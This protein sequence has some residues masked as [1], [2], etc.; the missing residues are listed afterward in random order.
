[1][2][3]KKVGL[4]ATN[5]ILSILGIL[6]LSS[7]IILPPVFRTYMKEEVVEEPPKEEIKIGTTTCQNENLVSTDY[8]DNEI[9]VFTHHNQKIQEFTRNTNRTYIDPLVYQEQKSLYGKYVTAFSIINGYEYGAI[10]DDDNASFQI[11]EKYDLTTFK[12]TTI[13]IPGDENSTAITTDYELNGS[14][15]KVKDYLA[16]NG[17]TCLDNES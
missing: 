7:F 12:P 2:K 10:P 6:V 11:R 15:T 1:M 9:L 8:I 3:E 5:W 4:T 17:Y 16:T 14:I 13:T